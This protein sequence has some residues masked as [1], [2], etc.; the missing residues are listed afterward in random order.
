M[1]LIW[2]KMKASR[3]RK[4]SYHDKTI[5]DLEFQE[6]DHIFLRVTSGTSVGRALKSRM[7]TPRFIGSYQIF[8]RVR[9]VAFRMVLPSNLSNMHNVFHV[10]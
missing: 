9:P 3:S 1:K 4:K 6:G 7:L 8:G 10:S 5:K 2:E